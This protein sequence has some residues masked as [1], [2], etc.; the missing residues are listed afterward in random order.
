MLCI[1]KPGG[2]RTIVRVNAQPVFAGDAVVSVVSTLTDVTKER[3]TTEQLRS[4]IRSDATGSSCR[5]RNGEIVSCNPAAERI[6]GVST[7][8]MTGRTSMDPAGRRLAKTAHSFPGD[9]HPAMVALRTGQP[10]RGGDHV[11]HTG[12]PAS[13]AWL[14]VTPTYLV[15]RFRADRRRRHVCRHHPVSRRRTSHAV[16]ARSRV[17]PL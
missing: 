15:R 13:A 9:A 17:G 1:T 16:S 8:Q 11:S 7:D 4:V 2:E 5:G 12:R 14:S 10:Q 3:Q 6:L